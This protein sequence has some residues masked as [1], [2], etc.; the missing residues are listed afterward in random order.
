[1]NGYTSEQDDFYAIKEEIPL[2]N[3]TI[4]IKI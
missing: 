4:K 3:I 1:M 2:T